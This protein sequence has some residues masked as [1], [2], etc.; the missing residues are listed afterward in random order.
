MVN[1]RKE[2]RFHVHGNARRAIQE[3]SV[4]ELGMIILFI[5]FTFHK[6]ILYFL[7][8]P[9]CSFVRPPVPRKNFEIFTATIRRRRNCRRI[10]KVCTTILIMLT[11]LLSRVEEEENFGSRPRKWNRIVRSKLIIRFFLPP[12]PVVVLHNI[13]PLTVL[14]LHYLLFLLGPS[15]LQL[16]VYIC[17]VILYAPCSG[18]PLDRHLA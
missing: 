14:L 15:Q 18:C 11:F 3:I 7:L 9:L 5:K 10:A 1:C 4:Q 6:L 12:P 8:H 13:T 17:S 16:R 2:K